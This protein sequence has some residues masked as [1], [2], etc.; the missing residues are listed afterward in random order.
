MKENKSIPSSVTGKSSILTVVEEFRQIVNSAK[1]KSE[2]IEIF[3]FLYLNI[4][5]VVRNS[6][7]SKI[8]ESLHIVIDFVSKNSLFEKRGNTVS[9]TSLTLP[10][11]FF[12]IP[13]YLRELIVQGLQKFPDIS[14]PSLTQPESITFS[15]RKSL[16]LDIEEILKTPGGENKVN[17]EITSIVNSFNSLSLLIEYLGE[18]NIFKS[19]ALNVL[20]I[21]T[22]KNSRITDIDSYLSNNRVVSDMFGLQ[23][24]IRELGIKEWKR[25]HK[26]DNVGDLIYGSRLR[27][28]IKILKNFYL[29]DDEILYSMRM[30]MLENIT[31]INFMYSYLQDF[32]EVANEIR[33]IILKLKDN[34]TT[35]LEI[36]SL[37]IDI[38][39]PSDLTSV[40]DKSF[41]LYKI[42]TLAFEEWRRSHSPES[43]FTG[44]FLLEWRETLSQC[45][46]SSS[47]ISELS[48]LKEILVSL[49][50]DTY[51]ID[52]MIDKFGMMQESIEKDNAVKIYGD[53][54]YPYGLGL[55]G[56]YK[57]IQE[58]IYDSRRKAFLP[59]R[60]SQKK[61]NSSS[62]WFQRL[63]R[64]FQSKL[65]EPQ[66]IPEV[67]TRTQ[68]LRELK[69]FRS[70]QP[71]NVQ[72]FLKEYEK[73]FDQ[74]FQLDPI[75]IGD[76]VFIG[77]SF[78]D[79][80]HKLKI[81]L[82]RSIEKNGSKSK[83]I[84]SL[85]FFRM[86]G[87]D[88]QPKAIY[89]I[90]PG[91]ILMK[92]NHL[93]PE[94]HYATSGKIPQ[95]MIEYLGDFDNSKSEYIFSKFLPFSTDAMHSR[96]EIKNPKLRESI[97]Q[98]KDIYLIVNNC[99]FSSDYGSITID[100][101]FLNQIKDQKTREFLNQFKSRRAGMLKE[102]DVSMIREFILNKLSSINIEPVPSFENDVPIKSYNS[103]DVRIEEYKVQT[104]E[105]DSLIFYMGLTK[106]GTIYVDRVC[107]EP[108][109]VTEY[110]TESS[111][112]N[113]GFL[114]YKP[115]DYPKQVVLL[116]SEPL[117][118]SR[119]VS[120]RSTFD[121]LPL[122]K[123][124]K[125]SLQRRGLL[126]EVN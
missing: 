19:S 25:T 70:I 2:L 40:I 10:V 39:I 96:I 33:N 102:E 98:Y 69:S 43:K 101:S 61:H 65:S 108:C 93:D 115:H 50:L 45:K 41:L 7:D 53:D 30:Y 85:R 3:N 4:L 59:P 13:P 87:S 67:I 106:D 72:R 32:P 75:V 119:Y 34:S 84:W 114:T 6:D 26:I 73:S 58:S 20:R 1:S 79:G 22:D 94:H 63:G 14:R 24:K 36:Q 111:I 49:N 38:T 56:L 103:G 47:V 122:I 52:A 109:G 124:Y 126:K 104:P 118:N 23:S 21:A 88:L 92:E 91:G 57:K 112:V 55:E 113:M 74:I 117:K 110:G 51:D 125:Q 97:S 89:G 15:R 27:E 81:V 11:E 86:S 44:D 9:Q 121:V 29:S 83:P 90:H 17:Q 71:E 68:V 18:G 28:D 16:T 35:A 37:N 60:E 12:S 54:S 46:D 48:K 31:N 42:K 64:W 62:T 82:Q 123:S 99:G 5:R 120:L 8:A 107:S 100:L 105:G 77:S 80:S 116:N 95:E 66:E 76:H 78:V